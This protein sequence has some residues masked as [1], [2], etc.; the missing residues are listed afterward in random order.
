MTLIIISVTHR[1][2]ESRLH[3]WARRVFLLYQFLLYRFLLCR[4]SSSTDA[5][6]RFLLSST[7]SSSTDSSSTDSSSTDSYS[8]ELEYVPTCTAVQQYLFLRI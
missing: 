3:P 7:D 8:Y 5:E 2:V 4:D 1:A 6:I